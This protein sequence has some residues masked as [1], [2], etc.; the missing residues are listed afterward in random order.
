M[1]LRQEWLLG[2]GGVRALRALG[3]APAAWHANEG[4]AAFMMV[5]RVRELCQQ[6][7][8]YTEAVKRVRNGSVFTTHTPVPAGHDHFGVNEVRQC[9]DGYWNEMGIDADTFLRIG[10]MPEERGLYPRMVLEEQLVFMAAIKGMGRKEAEKRL[11]PW[12]ERF[13]LADWRKK[14]LSY[15]LRKSYSLAPHL[16]EKPATALLRFGRF[17]VFVRFI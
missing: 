9:A 8:S 16:L 7:V 1:S 12:L 13:G 14:K 3:I 11:G 10:Y 5:E 15:P 2:I 6:G 4:H 17:R